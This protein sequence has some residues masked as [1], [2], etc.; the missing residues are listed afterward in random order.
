MLIRF[1]W[2]QT[3]TAKGK[4]FLGILSKL[5]AWQIPNPKRNQ[6]HIGRNRVGVG[7]EPALS[8]APSLPWW[9]RIEERGTALSADPTRSFSKEVRL[10]GRLQNLPTNRAWQAWSS[11]GRGTSHRVGDTFPLTSTVVQWRRRKEAFVSDGL[12]TTP[13]QT[14]HLCFREMVDRR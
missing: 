1:I 9:E 11:S 6:I 14:S 5:L 8:N 4:R 13:A 10:G 3:W 12:E 2:Q 7:L